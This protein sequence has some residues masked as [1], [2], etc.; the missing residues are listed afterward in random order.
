MAMM[1]LNFNLRPRKSS[2]LAFRMFRHSGTGKIPHN[3][4]VHSQTA[5]ATWCGILHPISR[6]NEF[7]IQSSVLG[8]SLPLHHSQRE[9]FGICWIY[10]DLLCCVSS[11]RFQGCQVP[12]KEEK[13]ISQLEKAFVKHLIYYHILLKDELPKEQKTK[14]ESSGGDT[15]YLLVSMGL[16]NLSIAFEVIEASSIRALNF[17]RGVRVIS[18]YVKEYGPDRIYYQLR[19]NFMQN[20]SIVQTQHIIF[21]TKNGAYLPI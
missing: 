5:L 20:I 1:L 9:I 15:A 14:K 19:P 2:L 3:A 11:L 12:S 10:G 7:G 8:A 21:P 17:T 4:V 13:G 18:L 16:E 6:E